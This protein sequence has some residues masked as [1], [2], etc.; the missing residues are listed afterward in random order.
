MRNKANLAPAP[1]SDRAEWRQ[2][3][4]IR[5]WRADTGRTERAKQ[6]QFPPARRNRWG[7][8]GPQTRFIAFGSPIHPARGRNGAKQTQSRPAGGQ[9]GASGRGNCAKQSQLALAYRPSVRGPVVQ[10]NPI[11]GV[12]RAKR[13]QFRERTGEAGGRSCETKPI[14]VRQGDPA[15]P[16]SVTVCRPHPVQGRRHA[17]DSDSAVNLIFCS[18]VV[19]P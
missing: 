4:P 14:S 12:N 3:K 10:T 8:P 6:T 13:T 9:A 16:E 19:C 17:G 15:E 2:T 5:A 18:F 7:K 11:R 1:S